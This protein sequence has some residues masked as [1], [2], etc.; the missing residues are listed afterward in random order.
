[1]GKHYKEPEFPVWVI[2]SESHYSVLFAAEP[3]SSSSSKQQDGK[4]Q[5]PTSF[6]LWYYDELANQQEV[7]ILSLD[8]QPKKAPPAGP[9]DSQLIPTLDLVI[10]TK[11]PGTQVSWN[12][13]PI[14]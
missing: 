5:W 2:C 14:L 6:D 11:W 7:I 8:Q 1:M 12:I 13:D 3:L 10:R 4:L 9:D